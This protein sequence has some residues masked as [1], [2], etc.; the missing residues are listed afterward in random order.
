MSRKRGPG[1]SSGQVR[2]LRTGMA[3][4][5]WRHVKRAMDLSAALVGLT[6]LAPLLIAVALAIRLT[7]GSP[8]L[9]RQVRPGYGAKPF[10]LVKFRTMRDLSRTAA[11]PTPGPARHDS[12]LRRV[13]RLGRLLRQTSLDELPQLWN[14]ARGDMSLVGPRP[15][16]TE[17]LARY[18]PEEAR[19]H[20]VPP[21][22]TGWAQ[23][24]GRT[25]IP[26][27]ER[28]VLDVWYVDHWSM[29]LDVRILVQTLR[30]FI[31]RDRPGQACAVDPWFDAFSGS[32]LAPALPEAQTAASVAPTAS[33]PR[34]EPR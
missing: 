29:G 4:S 2:P 31:E 19:R 9:F 24:N 23:V 18:S 6:L 28:F 32:D 33:L 17:Y 1:P 14:I 3:G 16:F 30:S 27:R 5:P 25:G 13:S 11:P 34:E 26:M 15:L 21:G 22:L 7:M 8:V 12:D 20:D 10:E